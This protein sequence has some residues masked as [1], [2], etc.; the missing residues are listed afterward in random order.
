MHNNAENCVVS[1]YPKL[2]FYLENTAD[3]N[4]P[5]TVIY[6][7]HHSFEKTGLGYATF[8]WNGAEILN[9]AKKNPDVH[10]VFK[11]HPRF[12][13]AIVKNGIMTQAEIDAYY[14]AW[15]NL[16]NGSVHGTGDYMNLFLNSTAMITDCSSFLGEYY[17]TG[18]PL[19]HL[20]SKNSAGQNELGENISKNYYQVHNLTELKTTLHTVITENKDP[21]KDKRLRAKNGLAFP[22]NGSGNYIKEYLKN[23]IQQ[24]SHHVT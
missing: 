2:D 3:A 6:A 21:L 8:A 1:G 4:R 12:K 16:K 22:E 10:F 14:Q 11:P 24:G 7:P 23:I 5:R 18:N 20:I 9:F 19:I 13:F 17:F 15:Q